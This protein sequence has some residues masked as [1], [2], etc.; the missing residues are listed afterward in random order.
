M[1]IVWRATI[2]NNA[3]R[4]RQQRHNLITSPPGPFKLLT[5]NSKF[6]S[7]GS[8]LKTTSKSVLW[9]SHGQGQRLHPDRYSNSTCSYSPRVATE[10]CTRQSTAVLLW[11]AEL[12]RTRPSVLMFN[13]VILRLGTVPPL[14]DLLPTS[15]LIKIFGN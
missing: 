10:G 4:Y 5:E 15:A 3:F 11:A 6:S 9:V 12:W 2:K 1:D 8:G 7:Y 14:T 13:A